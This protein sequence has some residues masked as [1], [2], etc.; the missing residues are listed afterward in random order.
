[1]AG[2]VGYLMSLPSIRKKLELDATD[3]R[4]RGSWPQ[5]MKATVMRLAL[6]AQDRPGD[7]GLL[8]AN[9]GA[10][11]LFCD[12]PATKKRDNTSIPI[13]LLPQITTTVCIHAPL[14]LL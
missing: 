6:E 7:G 9:N 1:V 3:K 13:G 10:A 12:R 2:L 4:T 5:L 14:Q 11:K 8:I